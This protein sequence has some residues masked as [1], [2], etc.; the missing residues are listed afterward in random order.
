M[1]MGDK[2][3]NKDE[4]I[5]RDILHRLDE[6]TVGGYMLFYFNKN[7]ASPAVRIKMDTQIHALALQKYVTDWLESL[8]EIQIENNI[9]DLSGMSPEDLE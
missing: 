5:P 2:K 6:H 8:R 1:T 3:Q 7:D 9:C 4:D